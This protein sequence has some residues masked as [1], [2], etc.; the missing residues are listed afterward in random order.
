MSFFNKKLNILDVKITHIAATT[1]QTP[2]SKNKP[3]SKKKAQ[4]NTASGSAKNVVSSL[5]NKLGEDEKTQ[6]DEFGY[7]VIKVN[8]SLLKI[9]LPT[10]DELRTPTHA[11]EKALKTYF[12]F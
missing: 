8:S 5:A 4:K 1:S 6:V 12:K 2:P 3:V 9:I 7:Q 11:F 10:G